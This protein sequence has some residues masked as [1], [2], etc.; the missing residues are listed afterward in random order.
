M[1]SGSSFLDDLASS[2]FYLSAV[3][4]I[5]NYD[6]TICCYTFVVWACDKMGEL[7]PPCFPSGEPP[8]SPP[9]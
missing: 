4:S 9:L 6:R 2:N 7:S 1:H 8:I 5:K 3:A